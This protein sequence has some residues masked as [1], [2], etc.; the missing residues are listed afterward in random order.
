MH[1][2]C[3]LKHLHDALWNPVAC[4]KAFWHLL[5]EFSNGSGADERGV[6]SIV[7]VTASLSFHKV[8]LNCAVKQL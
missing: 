7:V 1:E 4:E 6:Q 5:D 3:T 2:K 8:R